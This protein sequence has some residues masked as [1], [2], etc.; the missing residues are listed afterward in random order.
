M[1][2]GILFIVSGPS[3]GGK[4]TLTKRVLKE[5]GSIRFAVSCTTREPR[6]GEIDGVDYRF[7]SESDFEEMIENKVL[8]NGLSFTATATGRPRRSLKRQSL[9]ELISFWI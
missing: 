9:R 7:V 8:P 6:P 1:R 2:E 3:G 5:V 4:T